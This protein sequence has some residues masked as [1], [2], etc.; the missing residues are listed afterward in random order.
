LSYDL[1]V[2][3]TDIDA[4]LSV[5]A[6]VGFMEVEG[7]FQRGGDGWTMLTTVHAV[8]ED[9]IPD[10]I[11]STVVGVTHCIDMMLTSSVPDPFI[12]FDKLA[13]KLAEIGRGAVEG[14]GPQV[15]LSKAAKALRATAPP[16]TGGPRRVTE[17]ALNW[18]F[19]PAGF[20]GGD[21]LER[22]VA[23]LQRHLPEALPRR[24]ESVNPPRKF[25][26][27]ETGTDHFIQYLREEH[28]LTSVD[29]T[30]PCLLASYP[31]GNRYGWQTWAGGA[32]GYIPCKFS[33]GF[34]SVI[35]DVPEWRRRLERAWREL[36]YVLRPFYG[37]VR[38]LKGLSVDRGQVRM[39]M[40]A[41]SHPC[42][43]AFWTGIPDEPAL[44]RVVGGPYLALWDGLPDATDGLVF[45]GPAGWGLQELE[46]TEVPEEIASYPLPC[47]PG[48][49]SPL[50]RLAARVLP[51]RKPDH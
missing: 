15:W 42:I 40:D 10:A 44:A 4:A 17:L 41:D 45:L 20:V 46:S 34:D 2:W 35:L 22:L 29:P 16:S 50:P 28:Y 24:Y 36:S 26:L 43:G 7:S 48:L 9:E 3:V 13:R 32:S 37:D 30:Q 21:L 5:L 31:H 27:P 6:S 1:T 38:L 11:F 14:L 12:K 33:L 39:Y 19:D 49:I 51:F 47:P 25:R 18:W 8:D 23:T